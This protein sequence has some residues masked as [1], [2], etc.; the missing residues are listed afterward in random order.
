MTYFRFHVL[1]N[2]PVLLV[3]GGINLLV[4]VQPG[5]SFALGLV[6]LAVL[7]FTTPWDN[8]AA[9]CGIWGFPT[10]RYSFKIGYLPLEEYL[11]FLLQS[12]NVILAER[13]LT[14]RF[15]FF[16]NACSTPLHQEQF[17][18][19][20]SFIVVWFAWGFYWLKNPGPRAHHYMRHLLF[21]FLPVIF[22][23]YI[24]AG[25]LI[26]SHSALL[27]LLTLAFGTYYTATDIIAV[28]AG[29]WFIDGQQTTGFKL[30][31]ILPWEE[32]VFFYLTSLLVAQSYLLLLPAQLR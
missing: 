27:L 14:R 1:F 13:F 19:L 3:L 23:Q 18:M 6:L 30:F 7:I 21:W 12:L 29:T 17:M 11:F 25:F 31:G 5:E 26:S 10:G 8:Y 2:L 28:R 24:I 20:F 32:A 15:Q 16:Q 9:A 22:I 4:P